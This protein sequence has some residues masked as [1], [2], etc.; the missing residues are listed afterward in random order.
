MLKRRGTRLVAGP[1]PA[2]LIAV[3]AP[4]CCICVVL[5]GTLVLVLAGLAGLAGEHS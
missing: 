1:P 5:V 3:A 4:P 2:V